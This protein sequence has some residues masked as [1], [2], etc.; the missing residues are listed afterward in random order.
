MKYLKYQILALLFTVLA[1]MGVRAANYAWP[2][3]WEGVMLQAFYWDSYTDTRW[4]NLTNKA[5]EYSQYFKLIWV[6]NSARA[7]SG[8]QMGYTPQYWFTHHSSS[9]GSETQLRKMIATY[10]EKGVGIIEDL[11]INHRTGLSG[12][13]DFPTEEWN[14]KT[15]SIGLD[16]ICSDDELAGSGHGTPTGAKDTG[17]NFDGARDL[18]HTNANVQENCKNYCKFLLDDLGYVGFRIDMAK[19]YAA[20]YTKLYNEY[21]K[22]TYSVA[23]YW[24]GS[25]DAVKA[26]IE[27]AGK[28]SA[29]FDFPFKYAVNQAFSGNDM[30]KLVWL[31][32]GTT[33]QPAGMI[34]YGYQQ[35]AV[36]FLDNHDTYRDSNKFTGNVP[37]ANAFMLCSPG[38]PCVFLPH[39]QEYTSEIQTLINVRNSVGLH[40]MSAVTVLKSSRD[41]YMAEVTGS[42]GTLVVRIGSSTDTPSG[43]TNDDIKAKGTLYC[44]WTKVGVTGGT[45]DPTPDPGESAPSELYVMGHLSQGVWK[46]NVGVKMTKSGET[47]TA[48]NVTIVDSGE[49]KNLGFFSFVT[50]LGTTGDSSE[51]DDVINSSD[52]YGATSADAVVSV[53]GS[54]AMQVFYAG[55]NASSANSW[56]VAPGTYNIT[57]DFSSMTITV[58][59]ADGSTTPTPTPD[60]VVEMPEKL[61]V[62]GHMPGLTSSSWAPNV[63][64][65]MTKSGNSFMAKNVT[66]TDAGAGFG[67][68]SFVT[69]LGTTG[70]SD[71]WD[72]IINANDRYGASAADTQA[73]VGNASAMKVF[74]AGLDAWSANSWAIVPGTYNIE[75]NFSDMTMTA[76][77]PAGVADVE[78][79]NDCAPVYYNLQGV[80]V[81][82]PTR[83]IY[84][85]VRGAKV[86]KQF[87]P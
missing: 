85:V 32:N 31:A 23:E 38:T 12:W 2:A 49:G 8:N 42:K 53:G 29:A 22:P 20:K 56:A 5:D 34:H 76:Y 79:D 21:S 57:A 13:T 17:D 28:Q 72:G 51:W 54:A 82:N 44:V 41:C 58:K 3:N 33:M 39:Y 47:F 77:D 46:T 14:G 4:S 60:P 35:Y 81:D 69:E 11:V 55:A 45:V 27:G 73:T 50:A 61:Y 68:F 40:N 71:E 7:G 86:A 37:A 62:M 64:V 15:W 75:A 26:W 59:S 6:P 16:G 78:L 24:D 9:F 48:S 10:K 66:I 36:T 83:G 18:D 43:Y 52:R 1:P 80:R 63:G 30:T 84:I 74:Y 87:V 67:Y 70:Q 25:Y 65:A 19:G